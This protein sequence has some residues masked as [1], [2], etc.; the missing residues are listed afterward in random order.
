MSKNQHKY[1]GTQRKILYFVNSTCNKWQFIKS[2]AWFYKLNC[3]KNRSCQK[4]I[5]T[6]NNY[7]E[8]IKKTSKLFDLI[9]DIEN[10]LWKSDICNELSFIVFTNCNNFLWVSW[11]NEILWFISLLPWGL[12]VN[13]VVHYRS[14]YFTIHQCLIFVFINFPGPSPWV[15]KA[16]I[17]LNSLTKD[18][19]IGMILMVTP[20][21][22]T[23]GPT[24][25]LPW[26]C[27]LF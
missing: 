11:T 7:S 8:L 13:R 2:W 25:V 17:V 16:V 14:T 23:M 5:L 21:L 10:S 12:F 20:L 4:I 24:T 22:T 19:R 3:F 15:H 9:L 27:H 1:L 26:L 18:T 6:R